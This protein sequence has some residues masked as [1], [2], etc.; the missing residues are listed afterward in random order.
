ME[1][2][3]VTN[4]EEKL[5]GVGCDGTNVNIAAQGIPR[6]SCSLDRCFLVFGSPSGAVAKRCFGKYFLFYD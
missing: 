5:I 1:F 4:W 3:G 2:V 6:G